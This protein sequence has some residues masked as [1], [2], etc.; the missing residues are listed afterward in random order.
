MVVEDYLVFYRV[1]EKDKVIE[2]HHILHGM[3]DI[4]NTV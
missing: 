3:K 1:S 4:E 2:V